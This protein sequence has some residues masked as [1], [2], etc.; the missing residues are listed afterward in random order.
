MGGPI[1]GGALADAVSGGISFLSMCLWVVAL[2]ILWKKVAEA[3][4]PM[5]TLP[6]IIQGHYNCAGTGAADLW[7]SS[8]A[9]GRVN[10]WQVYASLIVGAYCWRHL[11][12]L[13]RK[14]GIR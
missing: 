5:Q 13:K 10:N 11:Y 12:L 7:L 8:H 6:W 9:C 1:L 3:K 4:R 14:A 2:I